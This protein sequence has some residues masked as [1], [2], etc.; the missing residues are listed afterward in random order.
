METS[1]KNLKTAS[2]IV[3]IFAALSLIRIIVNTCTTDFKAAAIEAGVNESLGMVT[4]ILTCAISIVLLLPQIYV[5]VKGMKFAENPDGS[6]AHIVWA[7]ILTV[8]TV[9]GLF[10]TISGMVKS[11]DYVYNIFVLVDGVVDIALYFLYIKYAK[12]VAA[13]A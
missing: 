6:K 13:Q 9:I 5:G 7:I 3:L 2:I 4:A 11:G 8:C 1:K 12:Q 10:S